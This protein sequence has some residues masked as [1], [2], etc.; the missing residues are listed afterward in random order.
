MCQSVCV[1]VCVCV[2]E[3]LSTATDVTS[4]LLATTIDIK[5]DWL[6]K[7]T[8]LNKYVKNYCGNH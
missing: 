4:E 3:L 5:F 1:C 2:C 7:A 6:S 8:Y